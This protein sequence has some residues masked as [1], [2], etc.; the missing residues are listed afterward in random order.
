M[1]KRNN[2]LLA[3]FHIEAG[4]QTQPP[5]HGHLENIIN[6]TRAAASRKLDLQHVSS[7]GPHRDMHVKDE[8]L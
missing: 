4:A 3:S 1:K 6:Y 8:R 5:L 7:P 2:F